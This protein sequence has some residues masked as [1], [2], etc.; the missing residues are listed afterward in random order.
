MIPR[1]TENTITILLKEELEKFG[2]KAEP[3]ASITTPVGRR[4]V[5]LLC[6]NA[7]VYPIEAKFTEDGLIQAIAKIQNDYL[8]FYEHLGVKGG[9]ALLYPEELRKPVPIDALKS[10]ACRLKFKVVLMFPPKDSRNFAVREGNLKEIARILAEQILTPLVYIEPSVDYIISSLRTATNYILN[11]LRHV[12]GEQLEGIFGGKNVFKN[13]LTYEEERYPIEDLRLATA[14]LLVNQ[15]LFYH[16]LSKTNPEKFPEIETDNI[17]NPSDLKQYFDKVLEINYKTVFSY[18][19]V[20]WIPSNFTRELKIIIN[21]IKGLSP[22]K[23]RGDL[24]GTIFHDLVP[25]EIRKSVAAFYT[26]ILAAELL[27]NLVID[28]WDSKVADFACGSGGLLVAAYRRKKELLERERPFKQ[29]DHK[30]FIEKDLLGIDIMPFAANIA[31]CHLALQSPEHFTNKVQIAVWDSTELKP[32]KKIPT[33]ARLETVLTG[34]TGLE[35][36]IDKEPKEVKGVVFLGEELPEEIV[37]EPYDV[38]I[39]NPPFTRHERIP[40]EYK[41][42][43]YSRFEDYKDVIHPKMGY[44]G[45]FILLSDRFINKDGKI[46]LVL[47]ATL[48]R[49]KACEGIRKL[50]SKKYHIECIIATSQRSAFSE[51][52]MFREILLIAKK[53]EPKLG[54]NTKIIVLK[55]LPKTSYEVN[56]LSKMIKQQNNN[57]EDD[58]LL[59]RII[60]SEDLIKNSSNWFK[61]LSTGCYELLELKDKLLSGNKLTPLYSIAKLERCFLKNLRIEDFTA[62]ILHDKL[63]SEKR[64]DVWIIDEERPVEKELIVKHKIYNFKVKIPTTVLVKGLRRLS[65]VNKLDVTMISDYVIIKWFDNITKLVRM[66]VGKELNEV[67]N[68]IKLW[69]KEYNNRK[70]NI[71]LARRF[72]ISAPGTHLLAYYC[73]E[74]FIG[75][76]LWSLKGVTKEEAKILSLWFNSTLN[77]L[78]WII[79]R[80]ESR[81]AWLSM[82]DYMLSEMLVPQTRQFNDQEREELLNTFEKVRNIEFPCIL[83]QLKTKYWARVLIDKT[84]LKILGYKGDIDSL[85]NKIY[86]LLVNEIEILKRLMAEGVEE[87]KFE[88]D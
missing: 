85:L 64:T 11:G 68:S 40:K 52:V 59:V 73:E 21:V 79:E 22:E 77:I 28:R 50:L 3:F 67:K 87:D 78:Q 47:P 5:D 65:H 83:D 6:Q 32:G 16:V 69:E 80:G 34:Q 56:N 26:N 24:L 54:M 4:E 30:K 29:E 1:V 58:K 44:F 25:F 55:K 41:E 88:A 53:G 61:F 35:I 72:D 66:T 43:L 37:L 13:I 86:N 60:N 70:C 23:V 81:G 74:E 39:M 9:F 31:A 84:W 10:I 8:K 18:N 76:G 36:Y 14:Y 48:L 42:K 49:V 82:E 51:S 33:V 15:L 46:G 62:F 2:V 57:F 17:K 63:R 27:A 38:V 75:A 45:F 12:A 20:E 19:V 71:I 7:G